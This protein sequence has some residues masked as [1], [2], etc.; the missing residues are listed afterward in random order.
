M[1]TIREQIIKDLEKV[2]KEL[3]L[4]AEKLKL[5]H[6]ENSEHGDYATNVA[7]ATFKQRPKSMGET[8]TPFDLAN[9]IVNAWRLA[10]LP[11]YLAKI[12]VV[13][14]G[15]INLWLKNEVLSRELERVIEEKE[16]YGSSA[17][18][19]GK[20]ILLE[21]TSP[22]PQTT[23]M[24]G[25]LRNN[26]LGM[27]IANILEF[28]GAKVIK[29][30]IINDRGVHLCRA[31]WGYLVFGRKN[32]GLKK[33][34]LLDF[35]KISDSQIKKVTA[36][37]DWQQLLEEWTK[38]K[39]GWLVPTEL[40]LKPDHVNLIWYVL[41]S[42][43]YEL[44]EEVKKQV[45][46]ILIAWEAEEKAVRAV[47]KQILDWSAKGYEETYRRVGSVHDWFWQESD[48]WKKGKEI[49]NEG[50]KKKVFR[51]SEGAI[52]TNLEKYG[53]P[54][55]V[56]QKADGTALYITQDLAL[57]RLKREKF[58]SDLYIWDIGEEQT[59]YFKQLFAICEQLGIGKR[60]DFFHLA[61]ALINFKG[62]GKMATRRGDVVKA[63]EVLD[64]FHFRALAII[65]STDQELRGKLSQKEIDKLAET[66]ALGATKYSLLKFSRET[67]IY[68]DIDE[69]LALEGNSGPY[70]QY[71][72]AR[73]Q[74]VLHKSQISNPK[75]QIN[76]KLSRGAGS[77]S[78]GE[79]GNWKL[80]P[81]EL[82]ILR[83]LYRFP[84]IVQEAGENFAPNLLCNFLYDLCQKYNLFYN[85]HSILKAAK[86]ELI[87]FRLC[88]T[89]GVGQ[90]LRNGLT[91]LGIATPKR[92]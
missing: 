30:G 23:I 38:K 20:R 56:V 18:I 68:F 26:F 78:A 31:I 27:V 33:S 25:H 83:V 9:K 17:V 28:S 24:L 58:P 50:L 85:R 91:L 32:S 44:N 53:L 3:R 89:A 60:Q 54:D 80:E 72:Y 87:E 8:A 81:E 2:L 67:T 88:L 46:E 76:W 4:P 86:P 92:M 37:V 90:V 65:K 13:Q 79:T 61:Y 73:T 35:K 7:L 74:S 64:E 63:D 16:K 75:S 12:E 45:G 6:P 14:P 51:Q 34:Q 49:V 21:H 62:G 47:W 82:A 22:N 66:V 57:T 43:V 70:L 15:F 59:L 69:S 11:E 71:T 19:K 84:E 36:K 1:K 41:G 5:E 77:R 42:R 39:S 55:T 48:H 52:V 29:D 10:G 40:K